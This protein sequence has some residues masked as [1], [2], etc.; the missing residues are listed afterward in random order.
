MIYK[1]IDNIIN[2]HY[3]VEYEKYQDYIDAKKYN[4]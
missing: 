1:F 2:D 3:M 4:L